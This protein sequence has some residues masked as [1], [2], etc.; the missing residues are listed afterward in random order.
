MF[1]KIDFHNSFKMSFFKKIVAFVSLFFLTA[2]PAFACTI[3]ASPANVPS[4]VST[5]VTFTITSSTVPSGNASLIGVGTSHPSDWST[6]PYHFF[7]GA[8]T[9]PSGCQSDDPSWNTD[10][11][12]QWECNTDKTTNV[13]TQSINIPS[14]SSVFFYNGTIGDQCP[15]N[16]GIN[17]APTAIAGTSLDVNNNLQLDGSLSSDPDNDPLTYTWQIAGESSTR[18]GQKASISD[19]T[20]G[21]YNV[22]LTV[23]DATLQSVDTTTIGVVTKRPTSTVGMTISSMQINKSTGAYTI[24]GAWDTTN[25]L[26]GTVL[27]SPKSRLLFELQTGGTSTNPIYGIVGE[28][29]ISLTTMGNLLH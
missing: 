1:L 15:V 19:L 3:T 12:A 17:H 28:N 20:Q 21:T 6:V 11:Y 23:S 2:L 22:T 18:T 24:K 4:G 7:V 27:S 9:F 16:I 10:Q 25:S 8:P 5:P 14:A 26:F 29:T 13:V